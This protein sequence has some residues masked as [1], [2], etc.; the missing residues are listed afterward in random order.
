MD[1][2]I[3]SVRRADLWKSPLVPVQKIIIDSILAGILIGMGG[4]VFLSCED[5]VIGSVLFSFGLLTIVCR[6]LS[7][8]TGKIGYIRKLGFRDI[9]I[10]LM[11]NF[12]GTF[13]VGAVVRM[14]RSQI[15]SSKLVETKLHDS[16]LSIFFLSVFCGAL[17]Y[18]AVDNYKKSR[19]WFFVI[20]PVVIFIL[21]GF[22]HCVANM[23]F[24]T[25][26]DVWQSW[27]AVMYVSLMIA[28]NAIGSWIFTLSPLMPEQKEKF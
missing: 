7:L 26:A 20:L 8:Y 12:I 27:Q 24:F 3:K 16:P 15:T 13:F 11:G 6:E 10:T 19:S 25:L 14:T 28:G 23:F 17:M 9:V 4:V 22:E 5:R 21:S 18:L 2:I 1:R